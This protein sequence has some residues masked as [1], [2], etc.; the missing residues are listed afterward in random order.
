MLDAAPAGAEV[1]AGVGLRI[2]IDDGLHAT[3]P[4]ASMTGGTLAIVPPVG[5]ASEY[6]SLPT[7]REIQERGC[8]GAAFDTLKPSTR[9][10]PSTLTGLA[11]PIIRA[12]AASSPAPPTAW[13]ALPAMTNWRADRV[14]IANW[15]RRALAPS[16]TNPCAAFRGGCPTTD[17]LGVPAFAGD[18]EFH[19]G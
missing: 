9:L 4:E 18:Y 19:L 15:N 8:K 6:W 12:D 1:G 13:Q 2:A 10:K 17:P 7:E 14:R 5:N 3:E 11:G 16:G